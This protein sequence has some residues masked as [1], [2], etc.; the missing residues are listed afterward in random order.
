MPLNVLILAAGRGVRMRSA[1]PKVLH[2][3]AG[4]P[5]LQHTIDTARLLTPRKICVVY[6]Y[7]GETVPQTI[8]GDDLV[9]VKQEPQLGTGH[10]LMQAM[11]AL[12]AN[13]ASATLV[14]YGDVPLIGRETLTRMLANGDRRLTLLTVALG[15]PTGY[16]RIVRDAQNAVRAI[17]EQKDASEAQLNITEI[18]TGIMLI[19]TACLPGWLAKL[20]TENAQGEYYLTDIVA[21]AIADGVEVAAA[22]PNHNWEALGVNS[23][24]QLASLERIYQQNIA[25]AL[26]EAG[27]TL[28]DPARLDVRGNLRCG[29]D[30]FIDINCVFEGEV[31]LGD[32][33]RIGANCVV[34][35]STVGAQTRLEP[36]SLID[37]AQVGADCS[38]G[39]FARLR[40]GTTMGMGA[41][42]GNFVETKK[43][44][45][46]DGSKI[47]HLSYVG[48]TDVGRNVNI[49]AGT[50]T[51]NYDGV[52]K[53]RTVIED[54]AFIGSDT[55]L[56]AP[57]TVGRGATL[58]AGTTLTA[59][60]PA[61]QL[62]I[63][64]ARQS[65][66][67]GWKRPVKKGKQ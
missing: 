25:D 61:G 28:V 5:L 31:V 9:F 4:R 2:P 29:A 6:G 62:T 34:R 43:A 48:D 12:A 26:L 47:N 67:A 22:Q 50:I 39:P 51:C 21:L 19:P 52:N 66:I 35:N 53:H 41:K 45:I 24:A 46:G 63:S 10:A 54:D 59:D 55:Q 3:L 36:F 38:I 57:V 49:G 17:G 7:G 44:V 37:D 65:T 33:V 13:P 15:D 1:L 58:G 20:T 64:R 32:G 56:V 27:V 8:A 11:P 16:G 23:K 60:A 30:V 18:N 42:I 14:L 40:P